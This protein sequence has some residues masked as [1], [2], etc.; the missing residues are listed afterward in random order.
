MTSS[1]WS[2][3]DPQDPGYYSINHAPNNM[4]TASNLSRPSRAKY[5]RDPDNYSEGSSRTGSSMSQNLRSEEK[6]AHLL[7]VATK[8]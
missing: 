5:Y 3:L 2:R 8:I 1:S 6:D 7:I 4:E